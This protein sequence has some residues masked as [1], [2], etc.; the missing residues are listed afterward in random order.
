MKLSSIGQ[1]DFFLSVAFCSNLSISFKLD[2]CL[3]SVIAHKNTRKRNRRKWKL[4]EFFM[5]SIWDKIS[6]FHLLMDRVERRE[7]KEKKKLIN[8]LFSGTWIE[9]E[10]IWPFKIVLLALISLLKS[11]QSLE[12]SIVEAGAFVGGVLTEMKWQLLVNFILLANERKVLQKNH[13]S[14]VHHRHHRQ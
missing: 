4:I 8:I 13:S 1:W 7:E 3:M 12:F 11:N 5:M 6:P 9:F 14:L 10:F 2:M